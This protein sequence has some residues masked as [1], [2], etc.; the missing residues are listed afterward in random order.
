VSAAAARTGDERAA[1]WLCETASGADDADEF[2][3][4]LDDTVSARAAAH[5]ESMVARV[6][7]GEPLQYALGRWSFRRLDLMVDRRV[8]I[9]RPETEL[10]VDHVL[11]HL[12]TLGRH[13]VVADLGTGSGAIGLSVLLETPP[14]S[15]EVWMT[16]ESADALDVARANAAGVARS[17]AGARFVQGDWYAALPDSLRGTVDVV[18]SNPPYVATDDPDLDLSVR[19]WEPAD[20]LIAGTDGLEDIRV[21]VAGARGWLAPGGMLVVE[22]GHAQG[23]AVTALCEAAGLAGAT[24]LEDLAGLGRFVRALAP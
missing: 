17:A 11:A 24:V 3:S 1:R 5:L 4:M 10:I 15:A 19:E 14:G 12:R 18:V 20:A 7:A 16:D 9:P 13:A 6:E 2:R 23:A 21:I 22:T 8:L